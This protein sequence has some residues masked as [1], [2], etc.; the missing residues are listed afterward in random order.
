MKKAISLLLAL[1]MMLALCACGTGDMENTEPSD[2]QQGTVDTTEGTTCLHNYI[3]ATCEEPAI[4]SVC[5]ATEGYALGHIWSDA[6]YDSPMMCDV[7]GIT[8]GLPL[9][10][11]EDIFEDTS[12]DIFVYDESVE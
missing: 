3:P 7:C 9:E 4:C 5:G 2:I 11:P 10:F 12:D 1:L 6:T 8:E